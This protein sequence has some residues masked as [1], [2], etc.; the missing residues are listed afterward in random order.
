MSQLKKMQAVANAAMLRERNRVMAILHE[1][2]VQMQRDVNKKLMTATEKHVAQVK[3]GLASTI[4]AA[5]Q[6]MVM[7]GVVP[8]AEDTPP[9]DDGSNPDALGS[10]Q[11]NRNG[12]RPA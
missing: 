9:K 4:I 2:V 3:A 10:S 7:T 5:I 8:S 6:I 1:F 12:G 11:G